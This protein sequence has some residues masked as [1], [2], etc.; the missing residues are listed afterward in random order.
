[1]TSGAGTCALK[2]S[3][4][5]TDVYKAAT[6]TQRT[7][8]EKIAPTV[9]FTGAP[10]SAAYLST[11][12]VT[13]TTNDGV[14]PTITSTTGTVCSVSSGVVTMKNG[15]GT[16]TVRAL[17]AANSDYLA[18]TL[19][20][21]TTATMLNTTTTIT[22]TVAGTNPLRVTVSFTVSNGTATAVAG[23]V[24]VNAAS[25]QSCTG[26]VASGKCVLTF[27]AAETTT[28]TAGYAG[29]SDNNPSSSA[30]FPLTVY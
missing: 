2:A 8:A 14:T 11:F 17:W 30:S 22:N 4:P 19:E 15:T 5:A 6:A 7:T 29:N 27:T 20:Q 9:T 23:N 28:L 18:A 10:G 13:T 3:W 26:T 16:C 21:S 24:T 1:M 12:P 25:G